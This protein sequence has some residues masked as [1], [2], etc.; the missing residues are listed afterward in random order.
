MVCGYIIALRVWVCV[1]VCCILYNRIHYFHAY[2]IALQFH[3]S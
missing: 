3:R 2:V 1:I